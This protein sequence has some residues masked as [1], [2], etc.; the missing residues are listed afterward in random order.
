MAKNLNKPRPRAQ[1]PAQKQQRPKKRK[2]Q[3]KRRARRN[4]A[5]YGSNGMLPVQ[6]RLT[7]TA[8]RDISVANGVLGALAKVITLPSET[9]PVR[10]PTLHT[11]IKRTALLHLKQMKDIDYSP[12]VNPNQL[13]MLSSSAVNPVWGSVVPTVTRLYTWGTLP[14]LDTGA[15]GDHELRLVTVNDTN[16]V[17][18]YPFLQTSGDGIR[19]FTSWV[20]VPAGVTLTI[21]AGAIGASSN[22]QVR[23]GVQTMKLYN[24][25][26]TV[27]SQI[28][29]VA[30]PSGT[31]TPVV[32]TTTEA[33]FYRFTGITAFSTS[34]SPDTIATISI[35]TERAFWPLLPLPSQS[36]LQPVMNSMRVN[37]ASLLMT[38]TS[39]KMWR[40]G[41]VIG[42]V[43]DWSETNIFNPSTAV[44]FMGGENSTLFWSGDDA[45]KGCYTFLRPTRESLR[46]SDYT[47]S[48]PTYYNDMADYQTVNLISFNVDM[49]D[50]KKFN[51]KLQHDMHLEFVT[52]SQVFN[53]GVTQIPINEFEGMLAAAESILPF[54]ENPV[55]IGDLLKMARRVIA[56]ISPYL[57][58]A[59]KLGISGLS[60][61]ALALL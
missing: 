30:A 61:A 46:Y 28:L 17:P 37:T 32:S 49:T 58:P 43:M 48:G 60:N 22:G 45:A 8:R 51:L 1:N 39:A 38:N 54:T 34:I 16:T 3:N 2:Q 5:V 13:F 4:L 20:Y 47:V 31:V 50:G 44:T 41:S 36:T 27:T 53:L 15:T 40:G 7:Q 33:L 26:S 19:D 52:T 23:I 9:L 42:A 18:C 56:H 29:Q 24:G 6:N 12:V 10:F 57:K 21:S 55:H 59:M 11:G 25:T 14:H 35:G